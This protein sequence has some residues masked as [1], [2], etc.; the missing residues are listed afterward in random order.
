[1]LVDGAFELARN[2]VG[3]ERALRLLD[4]SALGLSQQGTVPATAGGDATG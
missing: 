1:M 2:R 4:G 3:E